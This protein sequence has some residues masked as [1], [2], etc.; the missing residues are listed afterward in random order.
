[1]GYFSS[2]G[3]ASHH[4]AADHFGIAGGAEVSAPSGSLVREDEGWVLLSDSRLLDEQEQKRRKKREEKAERREAYLVAQKAL[5]EAAAQR[6]ER[7]KN[8]ALPQEN[9]VQKRPFDPAMALDRLEWEVRERRQVEERAEQPT[10]AIDN[11]DGNDV[12]VEAVKPIKTRTVVAKSRE[13]RIVI[14]SP[15]PRALLGARW[16]T[17]RA[18]PRHPSSS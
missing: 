7:R 9:A 15:R 8:R 14:A 17:L 5:R 11:V 6:I 1:M 10:Q 12:Q 4:F 3:F 18:R 16:P 2:N 13:A